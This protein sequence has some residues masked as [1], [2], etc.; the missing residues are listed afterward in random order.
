MYFK[1]IG[2]RV[3]CIR[4][5][6]SKDNILSEKVVASF[7]SHLTQVAPHVAAKLTIKEIEELELWLKERQTLKHR[8]SEYHLLEMLPE[9]ISE[10][11]FTLSNLSY[12]DKKTIYKL[13]HAI[14][15]FTQNLNRVNSKTGIRFNHRETMNK[16]Q[17]LVDKMNEVKRYFIEP[18]NESSSKEVRTGI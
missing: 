7:D 4:E 8:S 10:A 2:S 13:N 18:N 3:Q 9:I 6:V 15:S 1:I 17:A 12:L 11:N 5:Q 16:K 14:E